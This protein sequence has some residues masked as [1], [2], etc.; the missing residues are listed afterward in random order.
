MSYTARKSTKTES[1]TGQAPLAR[2]TLTDTLPIHTHL[3]SPSVPA[4][5]ATKAG[6]AMIA[7]AIPARSAR[8][9]HP[10]A[11]LFTFRDRNKWSI[12]PARS[13]TTMTIIRRRDGTLVPRGSSATAGF[14]DAVACFF[15]GS[16]MGR[17]AGSGGRARIRARITTTATRTRRDVAAG[18][19]V[20]CVNKI[21]LAGVVFVFAIFL[22]KLSLGAIFI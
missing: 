18:R 7:G 20:P 1:L 9:S 21:W 3:S 6:L 4:K 17:D 2:R 12:T 15:V 13:V 14:V 19:A 5:R 10:T 22:F 11:V 8:I 16:D